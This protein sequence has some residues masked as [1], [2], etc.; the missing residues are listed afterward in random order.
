MD[1]GPYYIGNLIQL[2]GP[3]NH[4][5]A[6]ATIPQRTRTISSEERFG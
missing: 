2:I 3:V 6:L 4:V 5:T 1:L